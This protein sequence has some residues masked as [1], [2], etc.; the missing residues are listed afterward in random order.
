MSAVTTLVRNIAKW[1]HQSIKE[2]PVAGHVYTRFNEKISTPLWNLGCKGQ[3]YVAPFFNRF[4][5]FAEP[6]IH[7][8]PVITSV[9]LISMTLFIGRVVYRYLNLRF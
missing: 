2:I 5:T 9:V 6:K 8:K 7:R 4:R 3:K 1:A